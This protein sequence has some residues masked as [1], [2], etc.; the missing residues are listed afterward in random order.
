M[1]Y[2]VRPAALWRLAL[3]AMRPAKIC[4]NERVSYADLEGLPMVNHYIAIL[5]AAICLITVSAHAA[6][7]PDFLHPSKRMT[8]TPQ[9]LT[10]AS[11]FTV[12][13][14]AQHGDSLVV[15]LPE[16]DY[17]HERYVVYPQP[18][19][20]LKLTAQKF[21]TMK[22]LT[23]KVRDFVGTAAYPDYVFI[24]SGQ[25]TVVVGSG[26][27]TPSPVVNGWC[28]FNYTQPDPFRSRK[29]PRP[30][31]LGEG[32]PWNKMKCTPTVVT[33]DSTLTIAMPF[34]HGSY[35]EISRKVDALE[36]FV[37]APPYG[38]KN[39]DP[40]EFTRMRAISLKVADI[41]G[42]AGRGYGPAFVEPGVYTI[43]IGR[44][45]ETDP[46]VDG[47]CRVRYRPQKTGAKGP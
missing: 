17:S 21:R 37:V 23:W 12:N 43:R 13:M 9:R 20:P 14:P 35:L 41:E 5:V 19:W 47:W 3:V 36:R 32:S 16:T 44:A 40:D 26:F 22:S 28:D 1:R 15:L 18:R 11:T 39:I 7:I 6:T 34:P 25:Y 46:L 33:P 38:G 2:V 29:L 42:P 24:L 31:P 45:F 30:G 27:D 8:C 10:E 4:H